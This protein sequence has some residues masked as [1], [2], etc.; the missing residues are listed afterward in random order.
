MFDLNPSRGRGRVEVIGEGGHGAHNCKNRNSESDQSIGS[1]TKR[2]HIFFWF[3]FATESGFDFALF[4][5]L[6]LLFLWFDSSS[7]TRWSLFGSMEMALRWLFRPS[8]EFIF[9]FK[10]NKII[11]YY[12]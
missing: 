5:I 2:M 1:I 8:K 11:N 6:F 4:L 7:L 9:S 12:F 3:R 10:I